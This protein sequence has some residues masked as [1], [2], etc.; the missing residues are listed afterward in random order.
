MWNIETFVWHILIHL[1]L[2]ESNIDVKK[3]P[4]FME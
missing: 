3:E 1:K 4:K 2:T